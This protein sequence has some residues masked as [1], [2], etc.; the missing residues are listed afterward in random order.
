MAAEYLKMGFYLG[1]GGVLTFKEREKSFW[2]G[3]GTLWIAWYWRQIARIDRFLNRGKRKLFAEPVHMWQK[4]WQKSRNVH[5]RRSSVRLE[6]ECAEAVPVNVKRG[7]WLGG[8]SVRFRLWGR[9]FGMDLGNPKNVSN[10]E[11]QFRL[12][13]KIRSEL[14][15]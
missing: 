4:I 7:T 2:G 12:P 15:D 3:N 8:V 10:T 11:I 14:S 6:R 1:I 5:R 13:E 9:I